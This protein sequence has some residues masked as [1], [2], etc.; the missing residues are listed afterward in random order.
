MTNRA[1]ATAFILK[2]VNKIMPDGINVKLVEDELNR[3]TDIKFKA[4]MQGLRDGTLTLKL[5]VP[6]GHKVKLSVERNLKLA[7]ELGIEF[8]QHLWL[9]D[10]A[11][12]KQFLTPQKYLVVDLPLR[13]QAQTL[14]HKVSIADNNNSIDQLTDQPTGASKSSSISLPELQM[15]RSQGGDAAIIEFIKYRGGDKAGFNMMNRLIHR[16]GSVSQATLAQYPSRVKSNET[17]SSFLFGMN[18]DNTL[19][20]G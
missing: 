17:L 12:Q 7:K 1:G 5:R 4:Y 6:N 15:L 9:T 11:T 18:L 3:L 20:A 13:R 16:E 10:P 19:L 2:N 14:E 8:F